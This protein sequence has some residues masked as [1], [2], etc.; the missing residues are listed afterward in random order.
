[1]NKKNLTKKQEKEIC[2]LYINKKLSIVKTSKQLKIGRKVILRILKEKNITI[3]Y[4]GFYNL[5]EKNIA[6]NK[7]IREKISKKLKNRKFSSEVRKKM[8]DSAKGKIITEKTRKKMGESRKG[9][10]IGDKNPMFGKHGMLSPNWKNGKS[11]LYQLIRGCCKYAEWRVSV[12]KRDNFQCVLCKTNHDSK[13]NELNAHHIIKFSKI[14]EY[15]NIKTIEDS[16]D[17]KELWDVSNGI[18]LCKQCHIDLHRKG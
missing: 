3:R 14:I 1:M 15:N 2:D 13:F 8:S 4:N 6:K 18:T 16:Y 17:C 7:D 5:G 10:L 12:Y 11:S 9:K